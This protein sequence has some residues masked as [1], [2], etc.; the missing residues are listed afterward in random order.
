MKSVFPNV[1]LERTFVRSSD[2]YKYS[3]LWSTK[4]YKQITRIMRLVPISEQ[5]ARYPNSI[6]FIQD[7][8]NYFET[9]GKTV[10]DIANQPYLF[11]GL[12]GD[13]II[14]EKIKDT[15]F[16]SF[17]TAE[18]VAKDFARHDGTII[19]MLVIVLSPGSKFITIDN[20][21]EN[22]Y[23]FLPGDLEYDRNN[24]AYRYVQNSELINKYRTRAMSGGVFV[25]QE[26]PT[27]KV[28][29]C[30]MI[31][32]RCIMGREAEILGQTIFPE[33]EDESLKKLQEILKIDDKY[34]KMTNMIPEFQDLMKAIGSAQ[35]S[36]K[37][38]L[39]RKLQSYTVFVAIYDNN[40]NAN[41]IKTL[42][43]GLYPEMFAE[44]FDMGRKDEVENLIRTS[45]N[46]L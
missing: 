37:D 43:F 27:F 2:E 22:E 12:S 34:D 26:I 46:W 30:V 13:F 25:N 15:T 24:K 8:I 23:V 40:N 44:M 14:T 4:F 35:N 16:I 36:Q 20:T 6:Y 41:N 17:T 45:Y 31:W 28:A 33:N 3:K 42:H 1:A 38:D 21:Y 19:R 11:R 18:H 9:H 5:L 7:F 39:I 32:Y 29:S 10:I